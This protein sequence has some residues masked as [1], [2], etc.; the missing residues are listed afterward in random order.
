MTSDG[1]IPAGNLPRDGQPLAPTG[2]VVA[3]GSINGPTTPQDAARDW[4]LSLHTVGAGA[5]L[6]LPH[7]PWFHQQ[8]AA[9]DA[10]V[11]RRSDTGGNRLLLRLQVAELDGT[12]TVHAEVDTRVIRLQSRTSQVAELIARPLQG[13]M[14]LPAHAHWWV[15][16]LAGRAQVHMGVVQWALP[17]NQPCWLPSEPGQRLRI[18][19]GGELLL[20]RLL[21]EASDAPEL[22]L[23][24]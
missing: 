9:L 3:T 14:L 10:P 24:T 16:L 21:A 6:A 8:I 2:H 22:A 13:P 12:D 20:V 18:D 4:C 1:P 11:Q 5:E 23:H 7:E 17:P 19:G 15:W